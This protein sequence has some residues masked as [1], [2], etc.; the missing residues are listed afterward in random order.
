MEIVKFFEILLIIFLIILIFILGSSYFSSNNLFTGQVVYSPSDFISD[1][2]I[3]FEEGKLVIEI[4]DYSLSRYTDSN[5][6]I[7]VLNSNTIGVNIVPKSEKDI[8]V[9]DIISFRQDGNLIVHRVIKK[10]IDEKGVYFITKG[11]NNNFNDGKIR[12]NDIES[13]VVALIY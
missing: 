6:M 1:D 13:V 7:P 11:D 8:S 10:D 12:F 2:K 9:G 4:E 5:S 3:S